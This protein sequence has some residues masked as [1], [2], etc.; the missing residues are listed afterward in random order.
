MKAKELRAINS[1]LR[2]SCGWEVE[3]GVSTYD[4]SEFFRVYR[5][6]KYGRK[7]ISR[8]FMGAMPIG[9]PVGSLA[10]SAS[11]CKHYYQLGLQGRNEKI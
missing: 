7:T 6:E 2:K 8:I 11:L 4:A 3:V 9:T 1:F 10:C 5:L